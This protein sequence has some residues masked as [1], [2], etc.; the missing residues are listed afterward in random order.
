MASNEEVIESAD[1]FLAK[2]EYLN[3]IDL[4]EEESEDVVFAFT[5]SLVKTVGMGFGTQC[6]SRWM[7]W[8]TLNEQESK[9]F[10]SLEIPQLIYIML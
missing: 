1:A 5:S 8:M 10:N 9:H 6:F 7:P 2:Y 3:D 4:S